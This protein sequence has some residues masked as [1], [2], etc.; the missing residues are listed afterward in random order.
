MLDELVKLVEQHAGSHIINN[1]AIPDQ[2]NQAAIKDVA[3]QIFNGL[4]NQAS[5]GNL[6]QIISMFQGGGGSSLSNNPVVSNIISSV[7]SS[8]SSKFGVSPQA[9]QKMA[10]G[11]LP[12]VMNQ[13]VSKAN[14]PA[15]SSF[16]LGGILQTVS[17]NSGL[18]VGSLISQ[19][20]G[21]SGGS[22]LGGLG[23]MLGGLFGKK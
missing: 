7:A 18:D 2:Y 5:S 14:N 1:P 22:L 19:V 23:G 10:S 4:Q 21:N 17:G 8:L 16:D 12:T 6:T 9:A 15:D 3:S 13:L 20:T 11:L